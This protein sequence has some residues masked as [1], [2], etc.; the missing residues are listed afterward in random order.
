MGNNVN[1]DKVLIHYEDVE[2]NHGGNVILHNVNF[3][4]QRGEFLYI[5]GKVGSGK[6]SFLKTLYCDFSISSGKAFICGYDLIKIKKKQIPMLRKRIGIVFQDFQLLIDR[7]VNDNLKFVLKVTGWKNKKVINDRIQ[8]ALV[9]VGMADKGY[10]MPHELSGGEQQRIVI[11]RALLN[12]PEII[13]ADEP[14]GNLDRESCR[15]IVRLLQDISSDGT[16]VIM[17]THNYQLVQ[18]F[19]SKTKKCEESQLFDCQLSKVIE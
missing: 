13:L 4:Q 7:S 17:A 16:A 15:K 9:Q 19:P 18:E 10:K 8:E 6:S 14:T 11:A 3:E 12:F 2:I 1:M 5:I